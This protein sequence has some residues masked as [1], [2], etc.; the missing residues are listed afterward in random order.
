MWTRLGVVS[1]AGATT[2]VRRPSTSRDRLESMNGGTPPRDH[3]KNR[4]SVPLLGVDV[5]PLEAGEVADVVLE[6]IAET[7]P[8]VVG[9]LNLHG[10]YMFHTNKEFAHFCGLSDLVLID[11]A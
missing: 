9:N 3:Y 4:K 7:K 6:H 11:G 2:S 1:H 10:V 5:T 8:L